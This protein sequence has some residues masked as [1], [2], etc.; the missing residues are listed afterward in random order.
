M[1]L[2][3]IILFFA[4]TLSAREPAVFTQIKNSAVKKAIS[5]IPYKNSF[6]PALDKKFNYDCSGLVLAAY[7]SA[8]YDLLAISGKKKLSPDMAKNIYM[9]FPEAKNTNRT[10]KPSAGDLIFFNNTYDKN[11]N[12]KWDDFLTHVAIIV[13]T[14]PDG[15]ISFIH[16]TGKG[17]VKEY[18]NLSFPQQMTRQGKIINSYLRVRPTSDP[19]RIKYL[20][21][22]FFYCFLVLSP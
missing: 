20:A 12:G 13:K 8:G 22:N 15:T 18:I 6:I 4:A 21:A 3:I 2:K 1:I 9:L 11:R 7:Y 5:L 17:I 19:V 14:D 16:V 10:L